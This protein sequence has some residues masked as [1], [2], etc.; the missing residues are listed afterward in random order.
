MVSNS[1]HSLNTQEVT[2]FYKQPNNMFKFV[3]L[4][5]VIAAAAAGL[6]PAVSTPLLGRLI[7]QPSL[8]PANTEH[9]GYVSGLTPIAHQYVS[10]PAAY[11][12][13]YAAEHVPLAYARNYVAYTAPIETSHYRISY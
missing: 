9:A 7:P 6:V 4:F 2:T 13:V 1:I 3:I 11:S 12:A 8:A 5:A 10:L